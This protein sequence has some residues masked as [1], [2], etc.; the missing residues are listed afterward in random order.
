MKVIISPAKKMKLSEGYPLAI[1]KPIFLNK[2]KLLLK[3]IQKLSLEE[4]QKKFR[5]NYKIASFAYENYLDFSFDFGSAAILSYDGIQ[6]T[7][8]Q[9]KV[10]TNEE[11]L[12]LQEHLIILSAFYGLVRPLDEI[13]PY[14]LE[15]GIN[16]FINNQNLYEFWGAEIAKY[17]SQ[18]NEEIINLASEEYS[19]VV[20]NY[21][22]DK[23]RIINVYFY[24][25]DKG[26]LREKGVYCKMARGMMVRFIAENKINNPQQLQQFN[27]MGYRFDFDLSN[28][29]NYI[30][31]RK[32]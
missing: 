16:F 12:F 17:L 28:K 1:S 10:F 23:Q 24:D 15:M 32:L 3:E 7:Y 29:N 22:N 26:K 11:Y 2:S 18:D 6:Y 14:R 8:M 27:L 9:A 13:K 19:K 30:F 5:C 31:K 4:L 25:D 20:S 21:L